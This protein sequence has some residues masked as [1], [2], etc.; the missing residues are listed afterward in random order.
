[1]T[2]PAATLSFREPPLVGREVLVLV[3]GRGVYHVTLYAPVRIRR[4]RWILWANVAVVIAV[5][6][7]VA[8]GWIVFLLSLTGQQ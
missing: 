5:V 6:P 2:G 1:M 7:F 4:R 3:P 8:W